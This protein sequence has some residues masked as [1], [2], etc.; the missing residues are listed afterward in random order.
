MR[1]RMYSSLV[2]FALLALTACT[3]SYSAS[4]G[5]IMPEIIKDPASRQNIEG[6]SIRNTGETRQLINMVAGYCLHYPAEFDVAFFKPSNIMFFKSSIL[7]VSEPNLRIDVQPAGGMTVDQAADKIVED[8]AVPGVE[9]PKVE[10]SIGGEKAIMLDGLS[11]QDP[12]RQ[13][14]VLHKDSLYNLFF[15]QMDKD[16]PEYVAQ[17]E[18]LYDTVVASFNF[19]PE[20]NFWIDCQPLPDS[21]EDPS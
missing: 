9:V 11:G 7:N 10:M 15:I 5:Q 20:T 4:V 18:A 2:I 1:P 16:Q 14:V 6:K 19:R 13:V 8:Y 3:Q 21:V 12:N 17:A